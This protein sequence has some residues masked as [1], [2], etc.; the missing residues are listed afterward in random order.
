MDISEIRKKA[1]KK[2]GKKKKTELIE[3][4]STD[5]IKEP[6]NEEVDVSEKREDNKPADII[7]DEPSGKNEDSE[8]GQD[9]LKL[10]GETL[11]SRAFLN[12]EVVS[13]ENI[14]EFLGIKID[15]IDYG[16]NI[17]DV[18]EITKVLD[19]TKVPLTPDYI[20]GIISLRGKVFT[21]LS[22]RK[23]FG[24]KKD[25][26]SNLSRIIVIN[27]GDD[28]EIAIL[29]DEVTQV[30]RV[31]KQN[32]E[33]HPASSQEHAVNFVDGIAKGENLFLLILDI[34]KISQVDINY[35]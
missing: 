21:L 28:E 24:L 17:Q 8:D 3:E 2:Q 22:L 16:L 31:S 32:I 25:N 4:V 15:G 19:V 6:V 14:V 29:V 27:N 35:N 13:D 7:K 33:P 26:L 11:L 23:K 30:F 20:L 12:K 5:L 10:A 34:E 9:F 1:K 18:V